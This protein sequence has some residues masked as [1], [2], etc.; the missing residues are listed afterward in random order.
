[1]GKSFI[2]AVCAVL[3]LTAGAAAE[4]KY[5]GT[6]KITSESNC[7]ADRL[8]NSYSSQYYIANSGGNGNY[9]GLS[10]LY[11]FGGAAFRRVGSFGSIG[12]SSFT[13]VDGYGIGNSGSTYA[14]GLR[15]TSRSPSI[16]DGTS[17]T[18]LLTG[19]IHNLWND[20][21]VNGQPC[22]VGFRGAYIRFIE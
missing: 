15:L 17:N 3:A 11:D 12:A 13:A 2:G 9:S 10:L 1:M 19:Y 6:L 20:G 5:R 21:G 16:V 4:T 7:N 14:A 18:I 8:N 22:I